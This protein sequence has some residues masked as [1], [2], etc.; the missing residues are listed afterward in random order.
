MP[1]DPKLQKFTTASPAIASYDWQEIG[2]LTGVRVFYGAQEEDSTGIGYFLTDS[3]IPSDEVILNLATNV[4]I[5]FDLTA[6]A[7]PQDI[8]GTAN[9][10]ISFGGQANSAA[11]IY[12]T[13]TLIHVDGITDAEIIIG[14]TVQSA[15]W[16]HSTTTATSAAK[17]IKYPITTQQHFKKGDILRLTITT[18]RTG[19]W[20][21]THPSMGI[22]PSNRTA[23]QIPNDST[24]LKVHI[25]FKLNL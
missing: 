2:N 15:T 12:Y 14:A 24:Q 7:A 22:D 21:A 8:K 13:A 17:T 19:G 9:I 23:P 4:N 5:D 16:T 3:I 25:P 11:G 18:V 20:Q 6:F 1:L 10:S